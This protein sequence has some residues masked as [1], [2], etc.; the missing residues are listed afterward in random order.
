MSE[1]K[2]WKNK[3]EII[4]VLVN[5]MAAKQFELEELR[6]EFDRL[7]ANHAMEA[8]QVTVKIAKL[9]AAIEEMTKLLTLLREDGGDQ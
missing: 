2:T 1:N 7:D 3:A 4:D 6:E 5:Q 8:V 9:S